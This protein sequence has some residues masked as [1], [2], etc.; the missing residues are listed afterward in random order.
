LSRHNIRHLCIHQAQTARLG[1]VTDD[2]VLGQKLADP[3]IF[4]VVSAND[5]DEIVAGNIV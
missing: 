1:R 5:D 3:A 2:G 4:A